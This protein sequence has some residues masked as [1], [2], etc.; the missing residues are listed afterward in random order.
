MKEAKKISSAQ[1]LR[2]M[3]AAIY[4][5]LIKTAS[6]DGEIVV[7]DKNGNPVRIK[8]KKALKNWNK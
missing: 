8:A 2:S 3:K 1:I 6:Q 7:S 4:E 5:M